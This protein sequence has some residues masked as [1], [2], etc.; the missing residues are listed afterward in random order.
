VQDDITSHA[1]KNN[2]TQLLIHGCSKIAFSIGNH[3]TDFQ[4]TALKC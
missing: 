2:V 3:V 4:T 1:E